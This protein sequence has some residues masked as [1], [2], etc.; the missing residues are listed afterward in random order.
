MLI[1]VAVVY[2]L[3]VTP[4]TVAHL[5]FFILDR[6]IFEAKEPSIC[7]FQVPNAFH[8]IEFYHNSI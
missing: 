4:I 7:A 6:N 8:P 1:V 5:V 2:V 3:L